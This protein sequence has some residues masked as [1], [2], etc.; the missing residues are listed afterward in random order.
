MNTNGT[1][2]ETANR[3]LRVLVTGTL[4]ASVGAAHADPVTTTAGLGASWSQYELASSDRFD[5]FRF[6][7]AL[8][9]DVGYRV[10]H[11]VSIG[12]HTGV[13][14]ATGT[15]S[16]FMSHGPFTYWPLELG[17]TAQLVVL[18]QAWVAPWIGVHRVR[19]G[20]DSGTADAT[21]SFGWG[22]AVGV[23]R[24]VGD[25]HHLGVFASVVGGDH[26]YSSEP[27]PYTAVTVG[28]EHRR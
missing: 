6:G 17:I 20:A 21:L 18:D 25:G 16:N 7:Q 23:D 8:H 28:I 14:R 3:M 24:P 9:L 13:S 11:G 1:T 27:V 4:L 26:T 12:V 22:M 10:H 2:L 15:D 19:L 5:D